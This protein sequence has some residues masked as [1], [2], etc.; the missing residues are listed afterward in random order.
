LQ[1]S[2]APA[3][4]QTGNNAAMSTH[5]PQSPLEQQLRGASHARFFVTDIDGV[6]RG[7]T[8][9]GP[10]MAELLGGGGT[11]A[12]AVFGWDIADDL[13]TRGVSFA[14]LGTALGEIGLRLD[15][16]TARQV[17]WDDM[18]WV[19]IGEHL[20]PQ[21]HP[22]PL[23]PRQVLKQVLSRAQQREWTVQLGVEFEW[24]VLQETETSAR[25]KGYRGLQTGTQGVTNYSPF[26]V[27]ALTPFVNDLFRWLP[28]MDVPLEALHTEAGPG[29][30]E[31]ALH[32]GEAL[33]TADRAILFKQATREIGRRH[34]LLNTYMA[35]WSSAYGGCGQH[36]HQSLWQG[37]RN[38]F[39][40][41]SAP[42]G[43]SAVQR[44]YMAGQLRALPDL[45]A[46]YAPFINSYKR[47]VDGMLAPVHV[48]WGVDD[49]HSAL[50][51]VP[52]SA[53]SQR[54]ETRTP[55]ADANP[56]LVMAAAV[57]SGLYGI[58]HG[59]DLDDVA[60]QSRDR[61]ERL[62]RSLEEATAL[63]AQ[64]ALAR[65]LLGEAF[66]NH[67]VE[68]RTWEVR[69]FQQAVTDRELARYMELV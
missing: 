60:A 35:K 16:A 61:S 52:G 40:D 9:S 22:L 58:E 26:R 21:G 6:C 31:V 65:E 30:L 59:L 45:F 64:S 46:L 51:V 38:L 68:T 62:P 53:R 47:L 19:L 42:H 24:Y 56:Y 54:L 8:L 67:F 29:N 15:P 12:S 66:V 25:Q 17:P 33:H 2:G 63:M 37:G 14:G 48:N 41:A 39:H 57:A 28:A 32:H 27:D 4:P 18:R 5:T 3:A 1:P 34:G 20:D 49:R 23:C 44:Q 10:K 55:G 36:L 11:I 43:M 13:Y 69:R 7:K 50:R